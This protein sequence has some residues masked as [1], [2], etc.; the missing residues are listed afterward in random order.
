MIEI[1]WYVKPNCLDIFEFYFKLKE[2][3]PNKYMTEGILVCMIISISAAHINIYAH[4]IWDVL[5]KQF[6][7]SLVV[8]LYTNLCNDTRVMRIIPL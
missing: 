2:E 5:Y 1:F 7:I 8:K 3:K 4:I 6:I